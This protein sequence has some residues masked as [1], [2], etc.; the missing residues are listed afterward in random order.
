MSEQER[1][2]PDARGRS[3]GSGRADEPKTCAT[4]GRRIDTDEWHPVATRTDD[5]GALLVYAFCD[6]SC[7]EGWL[8]D[9]APPGT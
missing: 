1:S 5:S 6:V 7:R 9:G 8:D 2:L 4:C 3:P